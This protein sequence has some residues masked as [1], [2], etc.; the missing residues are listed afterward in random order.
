MKDA[1]H[2]STASFM[3][4]PMNTYYV[5]SVVALNYNIYNKNIEN[6]LTVKPRHFDKNSFLILRRYEQV[7]KT[8]LKIIN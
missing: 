7:T 5:Y 8:H 4:N 2:P 3:T 1:V 6:A